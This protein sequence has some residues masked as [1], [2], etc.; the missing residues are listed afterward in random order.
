MYDAVVENVEF[1]KYAMDDNTDMIIDLFMRFSLHIMHYGVKMSF[2]LSTLIGMT[3]MDVE[4]YEALR[5]YNQ[6]GKRFYYCDYV[7][8]K[9][10]V[11]EKIQIGWFYGHCGYLFSGLRYW[12]GFVLGISGFAYLL[13]DP[14]R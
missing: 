8:W 2:T 5:K 12:G 3:D 6:Q 9:R 14:D 13:E 1:I 10:G 11:Y 4:V 7:G